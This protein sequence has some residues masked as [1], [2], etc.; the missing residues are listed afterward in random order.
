M[1][2]LFD[3][4]NFWLGN[5]K[6]RSQKIRKVLVTLSLLVLTPQ[7]NA[8]LNKELE[9][10][11][12]KVTH[13]EKFG[14]SFKEKNELIDE[15]YSCFGKLL[16]QSI[17]EL[18]RRTKE[19][20]SLSAKF[21]IE[22]FF[23]HLG[24]VHLDQ[25]NNII[26]V[27]HTLGEKKEIVQ[28]VEGYKDQLASSL[29]IKSGFIGEGRKKIRENYELSIF[30]RDSI[31]RIEEYC[32]IMEVIIKAQEIPEHEKDFYGFQKERFS[33]IENPVYFEQEQKILQIKKYVE[34]IEETRKKLLD[35]VDK[36]IEKSGV[37]KSFLEIF[38]RE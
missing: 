27:L 15:V 13:K 3:Q 25:L 6:K 20:K 16:K 36:K 4:F 21:M 14:I 33:L 28:Y 24:C 11:S 1:E 10:V 32:S 30:F 23:L 12:A 2:K 17:K 38:Q 5:T 19:E 35:Y 7:I 34:S 22:N 29:L 8:M 37:F 26:K 18:K 31:Q 9:K